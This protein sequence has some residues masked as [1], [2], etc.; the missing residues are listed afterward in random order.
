L[1]LLQGGR[2]GDT[3]TV[4]FAI[5]DKQDSIQKSRKDSILEFSQKR[6]RTKSEAVDEISVS[7]IN[8][9]VSQLIDKE[10]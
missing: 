4:H 9:L 2:D 10:F 7:S 1:S 5:K 6:E 3:M 8:Q